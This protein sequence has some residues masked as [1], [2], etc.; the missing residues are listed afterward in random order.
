MVG[1]VSYAP[2]AQVWA[3]FLFSCSG[4]SAFGRKRPSRPRCALSGSGLGRARAKR[5]TGLQRSRRLARRGS[6]AAH[7][8]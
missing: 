1:H 3:A 8:P 6:R 4:V 2:R 7:H 5:A